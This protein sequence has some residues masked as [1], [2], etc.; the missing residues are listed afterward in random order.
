[1][2][3]KVGKLEQQVNI[4]EVKVEKPEE[5]IEKLKEQVKKP[6]E[7]ISELEE[8]FT[9]EEKIS[10]PAQVD[11]LEN[12]GASDNHEDDLGI[13]IE[14]QDQFCSNLD[15]YSQR[16]KDFPQLPIDVHDV[17][18]FIDENIEINIYFDAEIQFS[19]SVPNLVDTKVHLIVTKSPELSLA[20]ILA[21]VK[22]ISGS[23]N[24]DCTALKYNSAINGSLIAR[25][26]SG[27]SLHLE[28]SHDKKDQNV[29]VRFRTRE[30]NQRFFSAVQK[31]QSEME[32]P[33]SNKDSE[34]SESSEEDLN[35][36]GY[37][38]S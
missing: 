17:L 29:V 1:L 27:S 9:E 26:M 15:K 34:G 3:A 32:F 7:P 23:G 11:K 10:N 18:H 35:T 38:S 22:C 13:H 5:Q 28:S 6:E 31:F 8:K 4:P 12:Q 37:V 25:Q 20:W 19:D 36:S 21:F 24:Q 2:E 16:V 30:E 14:N 33:K